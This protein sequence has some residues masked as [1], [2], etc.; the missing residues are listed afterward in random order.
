MPK[1]DLCSGDSCLSVVNPPRSEPEPG[2]LTC[3]MSKEQI[4][5]YTPDGNFHFR[6]VKYNVTKD[7]RPCIECR[8]PKCT[9]VAGD[10]MVTSA[11]L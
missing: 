2:R 3:P 1:K 11:N 6:C 9:P 7:V 10:C 4:V 5:I 8:A